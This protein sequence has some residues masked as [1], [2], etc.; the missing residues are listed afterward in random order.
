MLI[1][2]T[3]FGEARRADGKVDEWQNAE[4]VMEWWLRKKPEKP[5]DGQIEM[6]L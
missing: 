2:N 1:E 5:I 4:E 3:L 6:E